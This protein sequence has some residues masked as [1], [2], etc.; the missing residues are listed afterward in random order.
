MLTTM[1]LFDDLPPDADAGPLCFA[2][3]AVLLPAFARSS[4]QQ[5]LQALEAVLAEAPLWHMQTPGGYTMS[6]ATSS[7]G[8]LGWVSDRQGYRYAA[9]NPQTHQLWPPMPD[10]FTAL[11]QQAAQ[12]AGYAHFAPEACLINAYAP[13]AKLS[14][15]QDR[16]EK[17]TTA[18]IV[19][20]SLGLPAVFQF[21]GLRRTERTQRLRLAHGD[22]VVWGG[23]SRLAFHGVL[24]LADGQHALLGRRRI[25]LTFRRVNP[26]A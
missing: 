3:G 25:N 19:S 21:G 9:H 23:P 12:Q 22:V 20:V 2:P 24:P 1:D 4:A 26:M 15:H 6:V 16:D 14:L 8:S 17:D 13:G 18:P 7:C 10:C 11:A 5:L